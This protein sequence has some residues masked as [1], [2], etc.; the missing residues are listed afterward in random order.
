MH[1]NSLFISSIIM[2]LLAALVIT[3]FYVPFLGKILAIIFCGLFLIIGFGI[4]FFTI[5]LIVDE[6]LY[7]KGRVG[8][9]DDGA[10]LLSE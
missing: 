5:Y 4:I 8:R 10:R 1:K 2:I 7:R 6:I 9:V 3:S